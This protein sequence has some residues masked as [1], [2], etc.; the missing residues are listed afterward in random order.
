MN[1]S[2]W[3][4]TC[5][6]LAAVVLL[7]SVSACQQPEKKQP[8]PAPAPLESTATP[9]AVPPPASP[10]ATTPVAPATKSSADHRNHPHDGGH[11]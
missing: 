9:A 3:F 7:V 2:I 8:A 6:K 10:P 5:W 4:P 1:D 11:P